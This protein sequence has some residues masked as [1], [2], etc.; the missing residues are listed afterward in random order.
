MWAI[1]VIFALLL[2]TMQLLLIVQPEHFSSFWRPR[3]VPKK[4]YVKKDDEGKKNE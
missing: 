3:P 1:I 2:I 4:V